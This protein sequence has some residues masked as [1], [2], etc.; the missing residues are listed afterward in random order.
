VSERTVR[1]RVERLLRAGVMR[2]SAVVSPSALGYRVIADVFIEVTP[3]NV[4]RVAMRL[5]GCEHVSY[6]AASIGR[7]DLSIQIC[8]HD[9]AELARIVEKVVAAIPGV[10]RTRTALVPWKL[11]DVYE[12]QIPP[13]LAD[14]T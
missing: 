2:V 10:R 9:E 11:K 4:E 1:Y 14:V 5:V 6:V 12:W 8:A 7:G 3:G 13:E